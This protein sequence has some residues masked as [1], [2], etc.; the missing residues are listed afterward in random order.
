MCQVLSK[1]LCLWDF[2]YGIILKRGGTPLQMRVLM[3][4]EGY[5]YGV[6]VYH[7]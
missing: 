7:Q 6:M 4:L 2:L 5:M 3:V 1:A